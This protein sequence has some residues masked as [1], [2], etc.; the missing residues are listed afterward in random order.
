VS[1]AAKQAARRV[2]KADRAVTE[3]AARHRDAL[4][5]RLAAQA[6]EIADQPPLIALSIGTAL[7][8]VA[9]RRSDL[10]RGGARMLAAH[11]LATAAKT[12][13]KRSVDRTRPKRALKEGH[14][15]QK[16]ESHDHELN[17]FPSGHLAGAVAVG[18][19]AA[20]EIPG[21]GWPATLVTAAVAAAQPPAGN[22]YLSDML[23]GAAIGWAAEALVGAAFQR[24][25][26]LR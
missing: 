22:H 9:L 1:G 12:A 21:T 20:H 18:R 17:S 7:A 11:L 6:A 23:A 13:I 16:G 19:A 4:P 5:A 3:Q 2:G 8:G 14:R 26:G 25:P 15:F 24:V 10:M